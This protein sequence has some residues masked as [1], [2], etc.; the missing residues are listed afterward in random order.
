MARFTN[1]N[2]EVH[3]LVKI[4]DQMPLWGIVEL[5]LQDGQTIEGVII[6]SSIGN[7]AGSAGNSWPTSYY[8]E[9]AVKSLDGRTWLIDFLDVKRARDV[10]AHLMPDF[11]K[12]GLVRVVDLPDDEK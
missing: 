12:V 4:Q 3:H 11:E 2:A 10:T 9:V 7:N 6:R 8:A 1:T 5:E